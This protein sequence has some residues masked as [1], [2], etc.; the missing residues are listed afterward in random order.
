M[1]AFISISDETVTS[2]MKLLRNDN[3][4]IIAGESNVAGLTGF[5]II[6]NDEHM[7]NDLGINKNSKILFL[8][9]KEIQIKS[10]IKS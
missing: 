9:Q 2:T 10:C 8:E 1:S 7:K 4:P 5:L 6:S 3:V